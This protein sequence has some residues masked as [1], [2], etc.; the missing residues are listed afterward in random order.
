MLCGLTV[1]LYIMSR[2]SLAFEASRPPL[3]HHVRSSKVALFADEIANQADAD[4]KA[5]LAS[6]FMD[7]YSRRAIND[8]R[9]PSATENGSSLSV[10]SYSSA[11]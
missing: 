7:D 8:A 3:S 4:L 9:A 10:S 1:Q 2:R 11:P 5:A 6:N